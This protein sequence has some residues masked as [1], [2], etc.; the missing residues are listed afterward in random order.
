M[1]LQLFCNSKLSHNKNFFKRIQRK[2]VYL[3]SA[4]CLFSACR[5]I[6]CKMVVMSPKSRSS[7]LD[8]FP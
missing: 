6:K 4:Y 2:P 7:A 8:G 3:P 1:S 5:Q